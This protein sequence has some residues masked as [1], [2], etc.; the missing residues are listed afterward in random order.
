MQD[1]APFPGAYPGAS[2]GAPFESPLEK[3]EAVGIL[4]RAV[5]RPTNVTKWSLGKPDHPCEARTQLATDHG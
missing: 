1:S 3:T 5:V 4:E 2:W